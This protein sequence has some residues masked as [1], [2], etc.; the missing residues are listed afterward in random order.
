[1][2]IKENLKPGIIEAKKRA[3]EQ[4]HRNFDALG[5]KTKFDKIYDEDYIEENLKPGSIK[6]K[7]LA[8]SQAQARFENFGKTDAEIEQMKQSKKFLSLSD[9]ESEVSEVKETTENVSVE[10]K[11]EETVDSSSSEDS[12][13]QKSEKSS[14]PDKETSTIDKT[15]IEKVDSGDEELVE[16]KPTLVQ[17][18]APNVSDSDDDKE[19]E[20]L[21][22]SKM[23]DTS[24]MTITCSSE[25]EVPDDEKPTSPFP[26]TKITTIDEED[27]N[28]KV[29]NS[30]AYVTSDADVSDIKRKSSSS[31]GCS[32]FR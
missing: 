14:N 6:A 27:E 25:G 29:Y 23:D 12:F 2:Y 31:F 30:S 4:Q 7:Q 21:E 20:E 8:I 17:N 5:T 13:D 11:N 26:A 22:L 32:Y 24:S 19:P 28:E 1:M 3:V 10:V 15:V 9:S 16:T 18:A